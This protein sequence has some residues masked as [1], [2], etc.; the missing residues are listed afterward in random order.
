[1]K[2]TSGGLQLEASWTGTQ[3]WNRFL[4]AFLAT[5]VVGCHVSPCHVKATLFSTGKVAIWT[6]TIA[7]LVFSQAFIPTDPVGVGIAASFAA[8]NVVIRTLATALP[9]FGKALIPTRVEELPAD[10][11]VAETC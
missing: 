5:S 7:L 8:D 2:P 4:E 6:L 1:M 11:E 3:A 10:V 9:F